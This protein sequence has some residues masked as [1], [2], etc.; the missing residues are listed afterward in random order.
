MKFLAAIALPL[1]ALDQITKWWIY[2]HYALVPSE[3]NVALFPE[4]IAKSEHLP[5]A[6]DVIPGWF[7]IVHWGNTGAAFSF[8][9]D[10]PWVFIVLSIGAFIGLLIAWKKNAFTDAP[11]RLAVPLLLGGILGNV[12]DRF[13]HGYVVDFLLVD[14]HV[15]FANPWPAFNVADSCICVAAGL[16]VIAAIL[17][18]RKPRAH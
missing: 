1:Y 14:L 18:T 6:H 5:L 17:D 3:R 10:H 8:L 9:S 13:I 11:S 12:T 16:F 4:A 2:T 15:R 7:S